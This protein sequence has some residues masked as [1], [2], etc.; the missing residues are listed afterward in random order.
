MS[1]ALTEADIKKAKL[2]KLDYQC[3]QDPVLFFNTML[4]TFDPKR[5]PFHWPFKLFDFQEER[6]VNELVRAIEQG[7]DIFFD[8]TREMGVS[9]TVLGVLLWY[10]KYRDASNFLVGS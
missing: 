6:I 2:L 1:S 5:R 7:Y 9:Y 3:S 10:W 4:W 8:K